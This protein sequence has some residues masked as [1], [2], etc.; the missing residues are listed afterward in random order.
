MALHSQVE[1]Y[2]GNQEILTFID[3]TIIQEIGQ[4]HL[5]KLTCRRDMFETAA[6]STSYNFIG[7]SLIISISALINFE[8]YSHL[9]WKGVITE[10][11]NTKG[12]LG[13]SQDTIS[14]IAKSPTIL[15]DDGP[16]YNSFVD[17]DLT[18]I[19]KRTFQNYDRSKLHYT[20]NPKLE[21][22]LH[23]SVQ[24]GESSYNYANRLARQ[25]GEWFYY[26]GETLIFGKTLNSNNKT[27]L[28]YGF[29]LQEYSLYLKPISNA[30]TFFTN[31]YLNSEQ[32][33]TT[34]ANIGQ[35][36]NSLNG[37]TSK[38][39]KQLYPHNNNVF[40]NIHN[41][42]N[43]KQRLD[44]LVAH[45]KK[46]QEVNQVLLKG[47]SDNPS[48]N[49]GRV[50]TIKNCDSISG[51]YRIIK[52]KH[53]VSKNNRYFNYF[54]AVSFEQDACPNTNILEFSKSNTQVAIVTNNSDPE[55]LS[56]IKAQF[57][58][59]KRFGKQTPWLRLLNPHSGK[60]K[61]FHFIP[62]LGEEVL[63]GF[64]GG[65]AER[66]FV[67]GTLYNG[68]ANSKDWNTP[69]NDVKAIRT[70][71]GHTI[72]L[73][74]AEGSEFI[75]ISDKNQNVINIDT[76]N[77]NITI[78]AIENLKL[79]AKNFEMN[80]QEDANFNIGKNTTIYSEKN[81]VNSSQN[82]TNSV[83]DKMKTLIGG[84]LIQNSGNTQ[85]QSKRNIKIA[86]GATASLQGG[87]NVKISKG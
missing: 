72:E 59:Q 47:K 24:N 6:S 4:H 37:F 7:E 41:D 26:N 66:P 49:V 78:T 2:I 67:L 79:N 54:E 56:R 75:T 42:N 36:L 1:L 20:I 15:L 23:Y 64:E 77:N 40:L 61:G 73:N 8:G 44:E 32:Q 38:K 48:I 68:N 51:E 69:K 29:D 9:K 70:R 31:D 85:I 76:A 74:D 46:G 3:L 71:S 27:A 52:V 80:I 28:T 13:D 34:T 35:S 65:N 58:W 19:L 18:T 83:E 5:V 25:Y 43:I 50:L 62:E 84:D 11:E 63:I 82:H 33:H 53:E 17:T 87:G 81:F 10:M 55:G 21:K 57:P 22:P 30:V 16:N 60:G 12:F 45:Q 14:F 86:C 39:S